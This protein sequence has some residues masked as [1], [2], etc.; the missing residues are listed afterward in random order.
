MHFERRAD[1]WALIPR[2][3][4]ANLGFRAARLATLMMSAVF[5]A[6]LLFLPQFFQ[7]ILGDN[8]LEA[9]AGLLPM[10][11]VFAVTS[12][13]AATV[14]AAGGEGGDRDGGAG[15]ARPQARSLSR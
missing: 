8:P 10:M 4:F 1:T 15:F 13:V 11:V 6:A 12:F 5:F 3:V 7:K 9:G 2:D 14:R